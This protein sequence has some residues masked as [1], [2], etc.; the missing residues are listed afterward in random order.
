MAPVTTRNK[1]KKVENENSMD[2]A[3][4]CTVVGAKQNKTDDKDGMRGPTTTTTDVPD[5]AELIS[6][7]IERT[8][9]S[10]EMLSLINVICKVI[11]TQFDHYLAKIES[12][13]RIK[14][15]QI[16]SLE[17]KISALENKIINLE[18]TID[19]V[20]QYERRDTVIIRGPS[21]PEE[22][23]N[24][25]PA[26][27]IVNT[28]KH[29]LHVYMTHSAINVAHRLGSKTQG[30]K[31]PILVKLQNQAKKAELVEACNT[32]KP[33]LYINESL[34]PKRRAI[35]YVIRKIRSQHTNLFQQC[36]TSDGRIVVKLKNSTQKHIITSEQTLAA[37]LDKHRIF[38]DAAEGINMA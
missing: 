2:G 36:C 35:Y 27:L 9:L 4:K 8:N 31:R 23:T 32:V 37:F 30:K 34:T 28:L 16:D 22:S 6:K 20:D 24:E 14:D 7:E 12:S 17:T 13:N 25:N 21:L 5:V 1:T 11:Q 29:Q 10:S 18:T 3:S 19:D 26:D 33:K 15:K 38:K